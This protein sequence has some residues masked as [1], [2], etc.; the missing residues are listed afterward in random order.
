MDKAGI[1]SAFA[2]TSGFFS[3]AVV[4]R[5]VDDRRRSWL[6]RVGFSRKSVNPEKELLEQKEGAIGKKKFRK[7]S[8]K[9]NSTEMEGNRLLH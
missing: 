5:A 3:N 2:N 1:G 8:T 6:Q 4:G 9:P 7:F